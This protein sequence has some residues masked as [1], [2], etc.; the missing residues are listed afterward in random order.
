MMPFNII[1]ICYFIHYIGLVFIFLL[2]VFCCVSL[3]FVAFTVYLMSQEIALTTLENSGKYELYRGE[4]FALYKAGNWDEGL[5]FDEN[6]V[7]YFFVL[8]K[9]PSNLHLKFKLKVCRN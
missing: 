6:W 5:S 4:S 2:F 7:R 8:H 1:S 3:L 9:K